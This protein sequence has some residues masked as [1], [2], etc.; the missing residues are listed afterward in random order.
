[1]VDPHSEH[2]ALRERI[3]EHAFLA[4]LCREL[5]Q[6]GE[7]EM[8]VL[9]AEVDTAGYDLVVTAQGITRH[10]QLKARMTEG[11]TREWNISERLRDKPSGCVV[12]LFVCRECLLT[13]EYAFFGDI[14][15]KR[16]PDITDAPKAKHTKGDANG[17]K[18]DRKRHRKIGISKFEKFDNISELADKLFGTQALGRKI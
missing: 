17:V 1:M 8:E 11:T 18:P 6:R 10:I 5:W 9:R 2:S 14:P 13:E 15:G 3:I 12:I 7:Y 4:D 16:L